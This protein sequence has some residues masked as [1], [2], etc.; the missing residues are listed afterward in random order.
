MKTIDKVNQNLAKRYRA[1]KLFRFGGIASI[2]FGL[3]CLV[4]LFTDII[5]QGHRAFV[6][7]TVELEINFDSDILDVTD[8]RDLEQLANANY[9]GLFSTH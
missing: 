3:M 8:A 2:G 9:D 6:Q 1:E 4:L 7:T 5:G